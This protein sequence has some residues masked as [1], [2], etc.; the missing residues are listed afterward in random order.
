MQSC[1][2][3]AEL[4]IPV[5]RELTG[6]L[7]VSDED[8]ILVNE[9]ERPFVVHLRM[10]QEYLL[11]GRAAVSE[12]SVS[13]HGDLEG[14]G[15]D[16]HKQYYNQT[17]GDVRYARKKHGHNLNTLKDVKPPTG[18]DHGRTL[19]WSQTDKK[20]A[21]KAISATG[22]AGGDLKDDY[23]NPT[24]AKLQGRAVAA[25]RPKNNDVLTW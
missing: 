20:W 19:T 2:F 10:L 7:K 17:R 24:V 22:A 16:E 9:A 8:P 18:V 14:L 11:C 1:V 12:A 6:E 4:Q 3:L 5:E 13:N 21:A 25:S 23:P 15:L